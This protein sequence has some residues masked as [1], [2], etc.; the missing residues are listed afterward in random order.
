MAT[1]PFL[2]QKNHIHTLLLHSLNIHNI[3]ILHVL[4]KYIIL[5]WSDHPY[6][7]QLCVQTVR[8]LVMHFFSLLLCS[9]TYAHK[10]LDQSPS[11]FFAQQS[12]TVCIRVKCCWVLLRRNKYSVAILRS[13]IACLKKGMGKNLQRW[14]S[15]CLAPQTTYQISL[16]LQNPYP[17]LA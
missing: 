2:S 14:F 8:L 6:N 9:P 13:F 10:F 17:K 12:Q 5:F 1:F 4:T 16:I 7:V 11:M 15:V 3:I